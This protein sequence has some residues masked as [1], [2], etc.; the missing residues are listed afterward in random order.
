[1]LTTRLVA[2]YLAEYVEKYRQEYERLTSA[3]PSGAGYPSLAISPYLSS[4]HLTCHLAIDGV[5]VVDSENQGADIDSFVSSAR[6]QMYNEGSPPF[7]QNGTLPKVSR[8]TDISLEDGRRITVIQYAVNLPSLLARLTFGWPDPLSTK[9]GGYKDSDYWQPF[10]VINCTFSSE[11]S[12]I[13]RYY[14]YLEAMPQSN[15][16]SWDRRS[17][18]SRVKT[19]VRRD[20]LF[21]MDG[22]ID[23]GIIRIF[24]DRM[25]V[26]LKSFYDRLSLLNRDI[27]MFS[28]LLDKQKNATESVF[29]DFLKQHP[30]LLD[31]YGIAESKPRWIYPDGASPIGKSYVEPDFII[32]RPGN[33]YILVELERPNKHMATV[34]GQPRSEVNQATFQIGE[35]VSYIENHAALLIEKYPGI[36]IAKNRQTMV[37]M[38]RETQASFANRQDIIG[39]MQLVKNTYGTDQYLLY[40][41]L[42]DRARQAYT[43]LSALGASATQ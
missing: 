24:T 21:S 19:D 39:Y 1:M 28:E 27:E 25:N 42:I 38:G 5:V 20:Y 41:D 8:Q 6:F 11:V 36:Q 33:Q 31:I 30:L 4:S 12:G 15:T 10:F 13:T 37:V 14:S 3:P 43:R 9:P 7:I 35:W 18:W 17:L 29:H 16:S 23:G 22:K 40:D 26:E 2:D 34:Q 32:R